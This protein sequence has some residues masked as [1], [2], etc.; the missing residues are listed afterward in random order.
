VRSRVARACRRT[1]AWT[2]LCCATLAPP[3]SPGVRAATPFRTPR[4]IVRRAVATMFLNASRF[5][6]GEW[7]GEHIGDQLVLG[8]GP[9]ID[10]LASMFSHAPRLFDESPGRMFA[11]VYAPEHSIARRIRYVSSSPS[12]RARIAVHAVDWIQW[13]YVRDPVLTACTEMQTSMLNSSLHYWQQQQPPQGGR[14][15]AS[16]LPP[17]SPSSPL[18]PCRRGLVAFN[19]SIMTLSRAKVVGPGRNRGEQRMQWRRYQGLEDRHLPSAWCSHM[20]AGSRRGAAPAPACETRPSFATLTR[21]MTTPA[22][23][24]CAATGSRPHATLKGGRSRSL[25]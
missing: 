3:L 10:V 23:A 14:E 17:S 19:F 6:G 5:G 7:L 4:P 21:E 15:R 13:G 12:P 1:L 9:A 16:W 25:R 20:H 18:P 8:S 24:L 2:R 22:P 11:G